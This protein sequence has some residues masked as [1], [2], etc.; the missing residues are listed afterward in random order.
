MA[1]KTAGK[2]TKA[3]ASKTHPIGK[4]TKTLG[5]NMKIEMAEEIEKRAES[6]HLSASKYVKIILQHWLDSGDKL[7]LEER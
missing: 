4:G 7:K 2:K 3:Q 6:M 1:K 5:I